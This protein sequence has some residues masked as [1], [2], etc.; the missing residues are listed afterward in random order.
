MSSEYWLII[1]GIAQVL[2][3]VFS[4][5]V[6]FQSR[7][8]SVRPIIEILSLRKKN[9]GVNDNRLRFELQIKNVGYDIAR[10]FEVWYS[11]KSQLIPDE[12]MSSEIKIFG[13]EQY[14]KLT[15][16]EGLNLATKWLMQDKRTIARL[17][18][19]QVDLF[20]A[21][22]L[23]KCCTRNHDYLTTRFKIEYRNGKPSYRF[24]HRRWD[25]K[26]ILF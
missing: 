13:K 16:Y 14:K 18:F 6:I 11:L 21:F 15:T 2:A 17:S 9:H 10:N 3:A 26:L 25:K 5:V 23:I 12:C 19:D 24:I 8:E 1:G 22:L 4:I 7:R 20:E